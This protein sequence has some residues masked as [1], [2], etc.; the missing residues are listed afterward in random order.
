MKHTNYTP[1]L[2]AL[3]LSALAI[4]PVTAHAQYKLPRVSMYLRD[5]P[6]RTALQQVFSKAGLQSSID[7]QINGYVTMRIRN[8]PFETAIKLIMR[9]ST[10]PL[11]YTRENGV[12]VVRQRQAAPVISTPDITP[13]VD[14][15]QNYAA[16]L[17]YY[18]P[19][20]FVNPSPPIFLGGPIV[21]GGPL[22]GPA[23]GGLT[24]LPNG[25]F[26][27]WG[28]F[29]SFYSFGGLSGGYVL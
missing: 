24:I 12:Y 22:N 4:V 7:P 25:N 23:A 9:N 1:I 26:G 16:T 6:V 2:A 18:N 20:P 11:T 5:V 17:P 29:G 8:Q 15:S 19:Y 10:T 3:S 14:E 28:G 27:G 13:Y 21:L